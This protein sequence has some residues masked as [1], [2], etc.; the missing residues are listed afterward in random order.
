MAWDGAPHGRALMDL[1]AATRVPGLLLHGVAGFAGLR[2]STQLSTASRTMRVELAEGGSEAGGLAS[3]FPPGICIV[4]GK[5]T[6]SCGEDDD[7]V[8]NSATRMRDECAVLDLARGSWRQLP[9][10]PTARSNCMVACVGSALYVLGGEVARDRG[11]E[12]ACAACERCDLEALAWERMP[13]LPQPMLRSAAGHVRGR[14][15]VAGG[16]DGKHA[17]RAAWAVDLASRRWSRLPPMPTR[18][19]GCGAAALAGRLYVVGGVS[20]DSGA[21]LPSAEV[22]DPAGGPTGRWHRLPPMP[23]PRER[24]AVVAAGGRIVV[25]GGTTQSDP[26]CGCAMTGSVECFDPATSD[27]SALP[28]L[29]RRREA[30]AA[31]AVSSK[32]FLFGGLAWWEESKN[33]GEDEGRAMV[34]DVA[35]SRDAGRWRTGWSWGPSLP[36]SGVNVAAVVVPLQ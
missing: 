17:T 5:E 19:S 33:D 9:P 3:V 14:V 22:F 31:V 4:G 15:V 30:P 26:G 23:T 16:T 24:C 13:A 27:W 34:L 28:H 1:T 25:V 35:A 20:C 7:G 18:R 21:T 10:M 8:F 36:D 32:V 29:L 11:K 6:D 12:E 2:A